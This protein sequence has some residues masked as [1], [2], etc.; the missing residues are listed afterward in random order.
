[1]TPDFWHPTRR[2]GGRPAGGARS[3][4]P[5]RSRAALDPGRVGGRDLVVPF[6]EQVP[7]GEAAHRRLL[8]SS[9]PTAAAVGAFLGRRR[10][11]RR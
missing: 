1:M 2:P 11:D 7:V 5:C 9:D 3:F 10:C 4:R 8:A 6:A